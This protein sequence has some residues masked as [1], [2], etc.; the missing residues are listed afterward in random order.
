MPQLSLV[1]GGFM[2]LVPYQLR[3]GR[4]VGVRQMK[5]NEGAE[6][7]LLK[8]QKDVENDQTMIKGEA[9]RG[10]RMGGRQWPNPCKPGMGIRF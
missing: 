9:W 1:K 8:E 2:V 10:Q 4:R 6:K 7:I 5:V 3:L